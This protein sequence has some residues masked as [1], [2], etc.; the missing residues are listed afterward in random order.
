MKKTSVY[1][2]AIVIVGF[3]LRILLL[4]HQSIWIDELYTLKVGG[5][6]LSLLP[7]YF[8]YKDGVYNN[9]SSPIYDYKGWQGFS[10]HQPLFFTLIGLSFKLFGINVF[11]MR[12]VSVIFGTLTIFLLY[13][14]AELFYNRQVSLLAAFIFAIAPL[15]I[16]YGQDARP[17]ALL[18]FLVLISS[19]A[20]IRA[21]RDHKMHWWISY[22]IFAALTLYTHT[23]GIFAIFF[24][25]VY[26]IY[27]RRVGIC[28]F[29]AGIIFLLY[30]PWLPYF[31]YQ[32]LSVYSL[33]PKEDFHQM[34]LL[35]GGEK[36][37]INSLVYLISVFITFGIGKTL[38]TET[39]PIHIIIIS[40]FF[41]FTG[42]LIPLIFSIWVPFRGRVWKTN[43]NHISFLIFYFF[44][45]IFLPFLLTL[46]MGS[47]FYAVR[48]VLY[49]SIPFYIL[50]ANGLMKVKKHFFIVLIVSILLTSALSNYNYYSEKIPMRAFYKQTAEYIETHRQPEDLVLIRNPIL[51]YALTFYVPSLPVEGFGKVT[52]KHIDDEDLKEV[53]SFF[54]SRQRVWLVLSHTYDENKVMNF[55][56]HY[57]NKKTEF[58]YPAVR[59][60]LFERT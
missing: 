19:Y 6:A 28:F 14:F 9:I 24:Q 50:I 35:F 25:L 3:F 11:A 8:S 17:Y 22:C 46:F 53:E 33:A 52:S 60:A 59:F 13:F 26:L 57:Y 12:I 42:F 56:T 21:L 58:C 40:L 20:L 18:T 39:S 48:Y 43:K 41:Y 2:V 49:S 23:Y 55:F 45:P 44:I 47:N 27:R 15:Q 32:L 29:V 7:T 34:P 37:V 36:N 31:V 16:H 1:L 10:S 51:K 4:T 54:A 38:L 5:N 30:L